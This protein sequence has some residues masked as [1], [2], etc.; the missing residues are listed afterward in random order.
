[1]RGQRALGVF[2]AT[3]AALSVA[4]VAFGAET[5]RS[6][7]RQTV[8]PIC[9]RNA[10]AN[11]NILAG[12]RAKVRKRDLKPA[13]RQFVRAS[14]A[15]RSTLRKLRRVPQPAAD[16][17]TLAEWLHGVGHEAGLLRATGSSLIAGNRRHAE[18]LVRKLTEGARETNAIVAGFAF[19]QCRLETTVAG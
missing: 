1:M 9:A 3:V 18:R 17:E 5:T 11:K 12:V 10:R 19:H 4:S 15:L 6:E 2:L 7:Y 13:G 14:A 16:G 8:E